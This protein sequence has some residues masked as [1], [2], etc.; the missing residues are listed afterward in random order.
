MS[1]PLPISKALSPLGSK[2]VMYDLYLK[3]SRAAHRFALHRFELFVLVTL[4]Y[5][6]REDWAWA[7]SSTVA[8]CFV[9]FRLLQV[10]LVVKKAYKY[11]SKAKL[12]GLF[13]TL[14]ATVC[15]FAQCIAIP[16]KRK[17]TGQ[18]PGAGFSI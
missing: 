4:L 15:V 5:Q 10:D 11:V 16:L 18:R 9:F 8:Y 6:T 14:S 3:P 17:Y 2:G 12:P 7:C 1:K 13:V